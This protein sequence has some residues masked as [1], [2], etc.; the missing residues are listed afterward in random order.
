[1]TYGRPDTIQSLERTRT[2]TIANVINGL[3]KSPQKNTLLKSSPLADYSKNTAS[4]NYEA[5]EQER[6]TITIDETSGDITLDLSSFNLKGF[7]LPNINGDTNFIFDPLPLPDNFSFEIELDFKQMIVLNED[8]EEI[9]K[10][11]ITFPASAGEIPE[12]DTKSGGGVKLRFDTDDR[13]VSWTVTNITGFL[14]SAVSAINASVEFVQEQVNAILALIPDIQTAILGIP[15]AVLEW[16]EADEG[17]LGQLYDRYQNTSENDSPINRAIETVVGHVTSWLETPESGFIGKIYQTVSNSIV[18]QFLTKF[19]VDPTNAVLT[20]IPIIKGINDWYVGLEDA[21]EDNGEL[22]VTDMDS[23][24]VRIVKGIVHETSVFV[25]GITNWLEVDT[26]VLGIIYRLASGTLGSILTWVDSTFGEPLR[27]F[28]AYLGEIYEDAPRGDNPALYVPTKVLNTIREVIGDLGEIIVDWLER[29]S[30]VLGIVYRTVDDT[31]GSLFTYLGTQYEAATGNDPLTKTYN[32]VKNILGEGLQKAIDIG[33][34]IGASAAAWL[35]QQGAIIST[36][37][38]NAYTWLKTSL[39]DTLGVIGQHIGAAWTWLTGLST[40]LIGGINFVGELFRGATSATT[41]FAELVAGV[42]VDPVNDVL[43]GIATYLLGGTSE[44]TGPS[45]TVETLSNGYILISWEGIEGDAFTVKSYI[46]NVETDITLTT[47]NSWT[48]PTFSLI[49]DQVNN[50]D[51]IGVAPIDIDNVTGT[52]TYNTSQPV[53]SQ[54]YLNSPIGMS[55]HSE[56]PGTIG[57]DVNTISTD[58]AAM[59]VMTE[60]DNFNLRAND[61]DTPT[62]PLDDVFDAILDVFGIGG[63]GEDEE[64]VNNTL[65]NLIHPTQINKALTFDF[66]IPTVGLTGTS[67]LGYDINGDCYLKMP[68]DDDVFRVEAGSELQFE[69]R[70]KTIK[71]PDSVN[72]PTTDGEIKKVGNTIKAVAGGKLVDFSF[73]AGGVDVG[74]GEVSGTFPTLSEGQVAIPIATFSA[75]DD[76]LPSADFLNE[77]FGSHLG[78]IGIIINPQGSGNHY[79]RLYVKNS[80]NVNGNHWAALNYGASYSSRRHDDGLRHNELTY[81]KK[82]IRTVNTQ[83]SQIMSDTVSMNEVISTDQNG[84][85]MTHLIMW[86][87]DGLGYYYSIEFQYFIIDLTSVSGESE[88]IET[89]PY[90]YGGISTGTPN[91]DSTYIMFDTNFGHDDGSIGVINRVQNSE[92]EN[93]YSILCVKVQD[94]W[95]T[96]PATNT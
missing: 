88:L 72:D 70:E 12:F 62:G 26:G 4:A 44:P 59:E 7:F 92:G 2:T 46:G 83:L 36:A 22:A 31:V 91:D 53:I 82:R 58:N 17:I 90:I 30:G 5:G 18:G 15:T 74:G 40:E 43:D 47:Q 51:R 64:A 80:F 42:V 27:D 52:F 68:R 35:G 57:Y 39:A 54:A 55:V 48:V 29:D 37:V 94:A 87:S 34:E 96:F 76:G 84:L 19:F 41:R 28:T 8:G 1:M 16:L 71:L 73:I 60:F 65:S 14:D 61:R 9:N 10:P 11:I 6:V 77:S 20:S 69:V 3:G 75:E 89:F 85:G 66:S 24:A 21:T 81:A 78:A 95:Y 93:G 49:F 38:S 56:S 32:M 86:S 33:L 45:V 63:G 13:G 23:V 25:K 67:S 50:A 79:I